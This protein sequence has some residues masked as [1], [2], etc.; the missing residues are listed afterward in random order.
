MALVYLVRSSRSSRLR[1][2]DVDESAMTSADPRAVSRPASLFCARSGTAS[3]R[4]VP[5]T[6]RLSA[7][8]QIAVKNASQR[9]LYA[10]LSGLFRALTLRRRFAGTAVPGCM[11]GP[12]GAGWR[13]ERTRRSLQWP[14]KIGWTRVARDMHGNKSYVHRTYVSRPLTST[15]LSLDI[16]Q[17]LFSHKYGS[18]PKIL[19]ISP[20]TN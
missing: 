1:L 14:G 2:F 20:S 13:E 17:S 16:L 18:L 12:K 4:T 7:L 6:A 19:K 5:G 11:R 15:V 3:E 9:G 10:A 8:V